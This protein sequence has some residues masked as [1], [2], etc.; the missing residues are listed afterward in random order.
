[1]PD[2][3][4]QLVDPN[5]LPV[6]NQLQ[7]IAMPV[8]QLAQ[9][10]V[11]PPVIPPT[12]PYVE[13]QPTTISVPAY[14]QG[15]LANMKRAEEVETG[16]DGYLSA[17]QKGADERA[18]AEADEF[19]K[20]KKR[21]DVINNVAKSSGLQWDADHNATK[22]AVDEHHAAALAAGKDPA[23]QFFKDSPLGSVGGRIG[24]AVAAFA[25]GLGAGLVGKGGNPFLDY[26]NQRIRENYEAHRAQIEDLY[27]NAVEKGKIEDSVDNHL[28]FQ[29][30][31][32]EVSQ[33]A[34]EYSFQHQLQHIANSTT[35]NVIKA[36]A[37]KAAVDLEQQQLDRRAQ[38]TQ[39]DAQAAA[40]AVAKQQ[41]EHE[42][43]RVAIEK[44]KDR[45][46]KQADEQ[47]LT[48][49]QVDQLARKSVAETGGFNRSAL[50]PF[51]GNIPYDT[52]TGQYQ[53][54]EIEKPVDVDDVSSVI[55]HMP[56]DQRKDALKEADDA[57]K[58]NESVGEIIKAGQSIAPRAEYGTF[59]SI[60]Q[61]TGE[62]GGKQFRQDVDAFNSRGLI[63]LH[64][65]A[66]GLRGGD[67]V[68]QTFEPYRLSYTD[69]KAAVE[70]KVK[71]LQ[72]ALEQNKPPTPILSGAGVDPFHPKGKQPP[73]TSEADVV[74]QYN[75]TPK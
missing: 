8:Q 40:A 50:A 34:S 30:H 36:T 31:A 43:V 2:P 75:G 18:A 55:R 64:K 5:Q 10:Q 26:L 60:G 59:N 68:N 38:F 44:E 23:A 62:S 16:P 33:S 28:K 61:G 7:P 4:L 66:I 25:S 52:K 3:S 15:T 20:A 51:M 1:M 11:A 39:Q 58:Y 17:L 35:S 12:S 47:Q 46:A 69:G 67:I 9:P 19:S 27:K 57:L 53:F 48:N 21:E 37:Q 72:A 14:R 74:K 22:Q 13:A 24:A 70:R 32:Q 54:P 6:G 71:G 45:L 73:S 63:A 42:K 65:S 49:E 56:K 41:A 29:L